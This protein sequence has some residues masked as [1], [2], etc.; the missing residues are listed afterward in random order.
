[1]SYLL[2]DAQTVIK[3]N[4][5][6]LQFFSMAENYANVLTS[7]LFPSLQIDDGAI[8]LILKSAITSTEI[9]MRATNI[10]S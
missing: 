8:S 3:K 10:E 4:V 5:I 1:M 9:G 7:Q 6:L 2:Y